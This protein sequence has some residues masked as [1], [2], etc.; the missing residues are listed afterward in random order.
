MKGQIVKS[1]QENNNVE[2]NHNNIVLSSP[3][4]FIISCITL[5]ILLFLFINKE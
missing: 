5:I 3:I 2:F 4:S 1:N